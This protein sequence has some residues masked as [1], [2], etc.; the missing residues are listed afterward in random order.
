MPGCRH[1][2]KTDIDDDSI[3]VTALSLV[4]RRGIL[5]VDFILH[6]CDSLVF[7]KDR[8]RIGTS[9]EIDFNIFV[10]AKG[11]I[12]KS[13]TTCRSLTIFS[14]RDTRGFINQVTTHPVHFGDVVV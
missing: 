12:L 1:V 9:L 5:L 6:P 8:R 14:H 13:V 11:K 3:P 2:G 7:P 10:G 4:D